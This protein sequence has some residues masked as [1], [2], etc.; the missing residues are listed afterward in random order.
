[1]RNRTRSFGRQVELRTR[2]LRRRGGWGRLP[3]GVDP[4]GRRWRLDLT[5][6]RVAVEGAQ[7]LNGDRVAALLRSAGVAVERGPDPE[8]M[9]VALDRGVAIVAVESDRVRL[10]QIFELQPD[11]ALSDTSELLAELNYEA[12]LARFYVVEGEKEGSASDLFAEYALLFDVSGGGELS[13]AA[14]LRH[15]CRDTRG[16]MERAHAFEYLNE[17]FRKLFEAQ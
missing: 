9:A 13:L 6:G 3:L 5:T 17:R 10:L 16:A 14:A 2:A 7:P 12:H 15:F 4:Q 1:M 8:E 11:T